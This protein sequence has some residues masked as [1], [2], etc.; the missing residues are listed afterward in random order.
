MVSPLWHPSSDRHLPLHLVPLPA[1]DRERIVMWERL[2]RA[3]DRVWFH[4][5]T[6]ALE[7][8]AYR[9]RAWLDS[10]GIA[11][12]RDHARRVEQALGVPVYAWLERH[13]GAPA[14]DAE[15]PCPAC[16]GA[17]RAKGEDTGETWRRCDACRLAS[18]VAYTND[19]EDW[20]RFAPAS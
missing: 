17:W 13:Y 18:H 15:R 6:D 1:D 2:Q 5:P 9:E 14:D 8:D 20:A 3:L 19:A 10:A 11:V 16:G 7:L 12:A 4:A